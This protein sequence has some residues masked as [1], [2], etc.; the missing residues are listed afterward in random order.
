[1]L[2]SW[3]CY[4]GRRRQMGFAKFRDDISADVYG[5]HRTAE[6]KTL[7]LVAGDGIEKGRLCRG[8][9]PFDCDPHVQLAPESD[10]GLHYRPHVMAG[11]IKALHEAAVDL[12]LVKWEAPQIA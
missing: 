9:D 1:M 2:I 8:F 4:R 5:G 12:D 6:E 10:D 11:A 3:S 7:N